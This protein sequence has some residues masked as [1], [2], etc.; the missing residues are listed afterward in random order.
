MRKKSRVPHLPPG[1]HDRYCADRADAQYNS[2][3]Y[4]PQKVQIIKRG[5]SSRG[6]DNTPTYPTSRRRLEDRLDLLSPDV[7]PEKP[8]PPL[9][10]DRACPK[11]VPLPPRHPVMS[12]GILSMAKTEKIRNKE[13]CLEQPSNL[14]RRST[15]PLVLTSRTDHHLFTDRDLA[16]FS[17]SPAVVRGRAGSVQYTSS[18]G[19]LCQIMHIIQVPQL[20][21]TDHT[22]HRE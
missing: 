8:P 18:P 12:C 19:H 9:L 17:S 5:Y 16:S 10:V 22:Q 11:G 3:I 7:P 1:H 13:R 6:L 14:S 20:H 4:L 15:N 2:I 21:H